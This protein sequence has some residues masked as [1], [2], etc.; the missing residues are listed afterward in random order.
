MKPTQLHTLQLRLPVRLLLTFLVSL[1]LLSFSSAPLRATDTAVGSPTDSSTDEAWLAGPF[2]ASPKDIYDEAVARSKHTDAAALMLFQGVEYR[3]AADGRLEIQRHWI[4]RVMD[5]S[6]LNDW[7]VSQMRWSPWHQDRPE[8]KARVIREGGEQRWLRPEELEERKA[9]ESADGLSGDRRL[10]SG[11]LPGVESGSVVEESIVLRESRPA[12]PWGTTHRHYTALFIPTVRGRVVLDASTHLALRYGA[13]KMPGLEPSS[14]E[15]ADGRVRVVFDFYDMP[16]VEPVEDGLPA[17]RPRYPHIAFSTGRSW[18][19]VATGLGQLFEKVVT[20]TRLDALAGDLPS[21]ADPLQERLDRILSV[22]RQRIEYNGLEINASA[23]NPDPDRVLEVGSGD[24]FDI[25]LTLVAAFRRVGLE[26]SLALINSGFGTDVEPRLPGFGLFNHA[27]VRVTPGPGI[28]P[29]WIDPIAPFSRPGELPLAAQGRFALI[30]GPNTE[31]PILTPSN[32]PE[33]NLARETREIWFSDFGPGRVVETCEYSGSAERSQRRITE[34]LEADARR[35]GYQAY[36]HAFH[37]AAGLGLLQETDARDLSGPFVLKLEALDSNRV[38]TDLDHAVLEIPVRELARRLPPAL[39]EPEPGP[40]KEEYVFPEPFVTEWRYEIY[41]PAGFV[42]L[43]LPEDLDLELGTATYSRRFRRERKAA[44]E[45]I[46]GELRFDVGQ[47]LLAPSQFDELRSSL[48]EFLKRPTLELRFDS[49][50]GQFL[51]DGNFEAAFANLSRGV[52]RD[53]GSASHRVRLSQALLRLGMIQEAEHQARQAVALAPRWAMA[54]WAVAICLQHDEIGRRF[55]PRSP[56]QQSAEALEEAIL[57]APASP[58]IRA[59][60]P[61]ILLRSIDGRPGPGAEIDIAIKAFQKWRADFARNDLDQELSTLL[62]VERRWQELAELLAVTDP[63]SN[64]HRAAQ[65][66]SESMDAVADEPD[67]DRVGIADILVAAREYSVAERLLRAGTKVEGESPEWSWLSGVVR[68]EDLELHP[69]DPRTPVQRLVMALRATT[70]SRQELALALHPRLLAKVDGRE[71]LKIRHELDQLVPASARGLELGRDVWSDLVLSQ[72][73]ANLSGAPHLG[74]RVDLGVGSQGAFFVT[75]SAGEL[76]IAAWASLPGELGVEALERLDQGDLP[77]A[78][79]WLD[80]AWQALPEDA[81][82]DP[83]DIQPLR[84]LW[85]ADEA[86]EPS[87]ET[88]RLVAAAVAA[89]SDR[90]GVS[91]SVLQ[92][93]TPSD[94]DF[95]KGDLGGDATSRQGLALDVARLQS[96]SS[97]GAYLDLEALAGS[98]ADRYPS[99]AIAFQRQVEALTALGEWRAFVARAEARLERSPNDVDAHRALAHWSLRGPDPES[100]ER[101]FSA[102]TAHGE[103]SPAD[104]ATW[105]FA[106]AIGNHPDVEASQ[107]I[108]DETEG[109]GWKDIL[110]LR[111]KAMVLAQQG[112]ALEAR[113]ALVKAIETQGAEA[114]TVEDGYILGR[115]AEGA[116]LSA[117]ARDLYSRLLSNDELKN[118][119]PL[120]FVLAEQAMDRL[121]ASG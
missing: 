97:A 103:L 88:L 113:H 55:S 15:V 43:E 115:I 5:S 63:G 114:V 27:L 36:A 6:A 92:S 20:Q 33:D 1:V 119:S 84:Y 99:S 16:A 74:Y 37:H 2:K 14:T 106:K 48:E 46:I 69:Q 79:R 101:H 72:L 45:R 39:L 86:L 53:P 90:S 89:P 75:Q 12:F 98:L 50:A 13:R 59:E 120:V 64:L 17:H 30:I 71:V 96:Y 108:L 25:A 82:Q 68:G 58:I 7:S 105:V 11:R 109:E 56:L 29:V 19:W 81:S 3:F 104:A 60:Y 70:P 83:I 51:R 77:G 67:L 34:G 76:R 31:K 78:R 100:A 65:I 110:W 47:R 116:G 21:P 42:L 8:I 112:R 121:R 61:R 94:L 26:S 102:V 41:P 117:V 80:W 28:D 95:G 23:L 93:A 38:R 40:R 35:R 32:R 66:L 18:N 9:P 73:E 91:L 54:H 118:R 85:R 44:G 49:I 52:E 22:V 111:A 24:G 87:A 10:L 57:L 62:T 4:Y 107:R